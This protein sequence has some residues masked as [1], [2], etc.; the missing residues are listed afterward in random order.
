METRHTIG[1]LKPNN[2][3]LP[4]SII[5]FSFS[6]LCRGIS[7][8]WSYNCELYEKSSAIFGDRDTRYDF[9]LLILIALKFDSSDQRLPKRLCRLL[10]VRL[11]VILR[12][13]DETMAALFRRVLSH[14]YHRPF[15]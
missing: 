13:F 7:L 10:M 11:A 8:K 9:K 4:P 5:D 14:L 15:S 1:T 12:H 3:L 6:Y 2:P